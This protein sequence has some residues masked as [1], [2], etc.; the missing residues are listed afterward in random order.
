MKGQKDG[1]SYY[2][3]VKLWSPDNLEGRKCASEL[4]ALREVEKEC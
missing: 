1:D 3:E 2:E 4:G